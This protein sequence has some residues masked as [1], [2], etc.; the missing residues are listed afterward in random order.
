M[1]SLK[2]WKKLVEMRGP[3]L[4]ED[5]QYIDTVYFGRDEQKEGI[6]FIYKMMKLPQ[7]EEDKKKGKRGREVYQAHILEAIES[8][9][10]ALEMLTETENDFDRAEFDYTAIALPPDDT[11]DR[12]GRYRAANER[13][14]RRH[15]ED[16]E[17]IRR[18]RHRT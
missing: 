13:E 11:L 9:V 3:R 16:L 2:I 4:D 8:E 18:L 1:L 12:I 15:L 14:F 5:A 10:K 17:T 6:L 7:Q